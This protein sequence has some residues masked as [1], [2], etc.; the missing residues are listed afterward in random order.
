MCLPASRDCRG[1]LP[2]PEADDHNESARSLALS[3]TAEELHVARKL[4]LQ[5]LVALVI[6][7]RVRPAVAWGR[8][9]SVGE[10]TGRGG[11]VSRV[12]GKRWVGPVSRQTERYDI[13][14]LKVS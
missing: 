3:I 9:G 14:R 13:G 4:L 1:Q 10:P 12:C 2:H 11:T 5:H 8:V 7:N 6:C